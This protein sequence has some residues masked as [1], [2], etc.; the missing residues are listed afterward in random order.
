MRYVVAILGGIVVF[1]GAFVAVGLLCLGVFHVIWPDA[2]SRTMTLASS[3]LAL[4]AASLA[5]WSSIRA[6]LALAGKRS[7]KDPV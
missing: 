7:G 1:L 4:A 6:T 5:A 2:T 3:S